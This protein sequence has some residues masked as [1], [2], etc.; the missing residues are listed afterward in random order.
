[1]TRTSAGGTVAT[2]GNSANTQTAEGSQN[3]ISDTCAYLSRNRVVSRLSVREPRLELWKVQGGAQRT[4][5]K[6]P[7]RA[8]SLLPTTSLARS[9]AGARRA[10]P[11]AL[12]GA[13][14]LEWLPLQRIQGLSAQFRYVP[15]NSLL[16][17]SF[18][19]SPQPTTFSSITSHGLH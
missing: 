10:V 6:C 17:G 7:F 14:S 13:A 1:M 16:N 3:C 8:K 12:Q 4:Q 19:A 5:W 18:G 2:V 11:Q 15:R 9:S